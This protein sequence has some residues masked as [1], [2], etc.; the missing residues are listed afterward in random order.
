MRSQS[1]AKFNSIGLKEENPVILECNNSSASDISQF[2]NYKSL[3]FWKII[4]TDVQK[5][6]LKLGMIKIPQKDFKLSH[7]DDF[8]FMFDETLEIQYDIFFKL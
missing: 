3:K 8:K 1:A 5:S 2:P 4:S 6:F 7:I